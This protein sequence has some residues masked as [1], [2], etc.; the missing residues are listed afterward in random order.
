MFEFCLKIV[1]WG[2]CRFRLV[3]RRCILYNGNS[4]RMIE[5]LSAQRLED[6]GDVLQYR[7]DL[8]VLSSVKAMPARLYRRAGIV[9]FS[10]GYHRAVRPLTKAR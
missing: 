5:K 9:I 3:F 2:Q 8:C 4:R 6:E 1:N 10:G 7:Y